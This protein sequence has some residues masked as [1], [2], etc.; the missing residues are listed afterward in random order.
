MH[1]KSI[2]M[3][4]RGFYHTFNMSKLMNGNTELAV[5]MP[6]GYLVIASGH[7]VRIQSDADRIGRTKSVAKLFQDGDVIDV[8]A[9]SQ[10]LG[11]DNLRQVHA[12]GREYNVLRIKSCFE[13][14]LYFLYRDGVE[15]TALQANDF[16][17]VDIGQGFAGIKKAGL[18]ILER[19]GQFPVL[20]GNFFC[21]IHI[22]R[23][24]KLFGELN[25]VGA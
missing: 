6:G 24:A 10:I 3:K 20:M 18:G 9:D 25:K 14:Q 16:Q 2:H 17:Y 11:C 7:D 15:S 8:D 13:T 23:S 1:V 21:M 4:P 5:D 19:M 12:I 22:E